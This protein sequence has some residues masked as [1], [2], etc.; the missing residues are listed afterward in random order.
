MTL[1]RAG[2]PARRSSAGCR[3][4]APSARHR[5]GT[6]ECRAN[7]SCRSRYVAEAAVCFPTSI[8][9]AIDHSAE[10]GFFQA[11]RS[12][13]REIEEASDQRIGAVDFDGDVIRPFRARRRCRVRLSC[14]SSSAEVFMVP[15]WI[16]QL[17]RQAGGQLSQRGQPLRPAHRC[18]GFSSGSDWLRQA[19]R[20]PPGTWR[21]SSRLALAS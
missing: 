2:W 8:D 17:V 6:A 18:L 20:P 12:G 3:S 10:I 9:G 16:A 11:Q 19:A 15:K 5:A 1:P 4:R 14:A 7:S 13:P 21:A